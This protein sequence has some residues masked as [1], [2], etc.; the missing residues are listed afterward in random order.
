MISV[1]SDLYDSEIAELDAEIGRFVQEL[2]RA[3]IL[4]ETLLIVTSDHGENLGDHGMAS[5]KSSLHRS[6][7]HIPLVLRLPGVFDGG[8][9]VD[10]VVRLEDLFP[11][12]LEVCRIEVPPGIQGK[13]INGETAGRVSR[14]HHAQPGP[15]LIQKLRRLHPG[16]DT[17]RLETSIDAVF[18]GRYHYIRYSAGREEL[19]DVTLDPGE[20]RDLSGTSPTVLDRLRAL[21]DS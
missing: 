3:G 14:A 6:I 19:Y 10:D 5:H 8:R 20:K 17:S 1:L 11:T 18:D 21:L 16:A 4:D 13:S 7:R 15:L 9:T 12:I 2:G